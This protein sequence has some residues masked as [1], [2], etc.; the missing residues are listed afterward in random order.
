MGHP[1]VLYDYVKSP[2]NQNK[3]KENPQQ[4]VVI[5]KKKVIL[6]STCILTCI[7]YIYIF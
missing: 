7:N 2:P 1:V 6:T 5:L 3:E 4:G